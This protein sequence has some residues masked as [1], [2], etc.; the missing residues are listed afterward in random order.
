[1]DGAVGAGFEVVLSVDAHDPDGG[2]LTYAWSAS[3]GSF[4]P[5]EAD[6]AVVT[7]TAPPAPGEVEIRVTV[8]DDEGE[9]TSDALTLTVTA[10]GAPTVTASA[11]PTMVV[12]GGA[13]E[14]TASG[15]SEVKRSFHGL[16]AGCRPSTGTALA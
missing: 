16:F 14:L 3:A 8:T 15:S 6:Q 5:P 9:T 12:P 11:E 2:E 1:M 4:D 7:W 10:S 13:V